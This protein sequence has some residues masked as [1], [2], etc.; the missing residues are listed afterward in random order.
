MTQFNVRGSSVQDVSSKLAVQLKVCA[1]SSIQHR[2]HV[3]EGSLSLAAPGNSHTPKPE[4]GRIFTATPILNAGLSS[5]RAQSFK[6]AET[7]RQTDFFP[8]D[9]VMKSQK[10]NMRTYG[11]Q[12]KFQL[13]STNPSVPKRRSLPDLLAL[14]SPPPK[15]DRPRSVDIHQFRRNRASLNDGPGTKIPRSGAPLPSR[16]CP[17]SNHAAALCQQ[18]DD[19]ELYDDC[20]MN[21]PPLPFKGH[22]SCRTKAELTQKMNEESVN[23]WLEANNFEEDI[24]DDVANPETRI[25]L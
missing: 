6:L 8:K 2:M 1:E 4:L 24:Y 15:P 20:I 3:L 23:I 16:S 5:L 12:N 14:G 19:E 21:R 25:Y 22:P 10:P 9:L 7:E 13:E 17:P 11:S 18:L